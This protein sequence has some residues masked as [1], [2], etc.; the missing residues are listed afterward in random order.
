MDG[1]DSADSLAALKKSIRDSEASLR[2]L[3]QAIEAVDARL[4]PQRSIFDPQSSR[5]DNEAVG[6]LKAAAGGG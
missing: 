1:C 4:K 6:Y 2:G 5:D 3:K